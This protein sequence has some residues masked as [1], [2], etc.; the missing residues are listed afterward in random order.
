MAMFNS[1]LLV[2][3]SEIDVLVDRRLI[4]I[5]SFASH[6][7]ATSSGEEAL[8]FL[9]EECSSLNTA[10]DWIFLD[11]YLPGMSGFEVI[12]EFKTL[13]SYITKK[14]RIVI[15]SV[16]QKQEEIEKVLKLPFVFGQIE[17]PLTQQSLK[18]LMVK[19]QITAS[20]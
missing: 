5:T 12:E 10:P 19:S 14:S 4:E 17:K 1:V 16:Y 7:T 15:L 20:S 9:R 2:D 18:A 3:D 13:P 11:M 8:K 6:T